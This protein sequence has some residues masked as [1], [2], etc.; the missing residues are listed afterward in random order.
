LVLEA[1]FPETEIGLLE[2]IEVPFVIGYGAVEEEAKLIMVLG[3]ATAETELREIE[4]L[5]F[6]GIGYGAV[7]DDAKLI[8]V[9]GIAI[10]G[11]PGVLG[12][13][14]V[15]GIPG[16]PAIPAVGAG[17]TTLVVE[18][19]MG[20]GAVKEETTLT[21]VLGIAP[22]TELLILVTIT[23]RNVDASALELPLLEEMISVGKEVLDELFAVDDTISVL[24]VGSDELAAAVDEE[25]EEMA[26]GNAVLGLEPL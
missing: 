25:D 5:L 26:A 2:E 22:E 4:L 11:T 1:E 8:L 20:Y 18:F 7:E 14:G 23:D 6:V 24:R 17:V 10:P 21:F 19:E 13:L 15:P 3:I 16:V 9:L 12:T